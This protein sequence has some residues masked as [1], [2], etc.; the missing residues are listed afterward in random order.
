MIA[1]IH[2]H[3][4]NNNQAL[5]VLY[6][7]QG[8]EHMSVVGNQQKKEGTSQLNNSTDNEQQPRIQ[9]HFAHYT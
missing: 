8:N 4:L 1:K 5:Q 3:A 7:F 9:A 6:I 2:M